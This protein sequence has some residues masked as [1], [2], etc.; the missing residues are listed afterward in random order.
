LSETENTGG[1]DFRPVREQ[2]A[3]KTGKA[4]RCPSLYVLQANLMGAGLKAWSQALINSGALSSSG[5]ALFLTRMLLVN[6]FQV[7]PG[8]GLYVLTFCMVLIPFLS[9]T[10]SI[11][12]I[13]SVI[14]R[15]RRIKMCLPIRIRPVAGQRPE[16]ICNSVDISRS[17]VL[18][19]TASSYYYVG[20]ET[21]VTRTA[22]GAEEHAS[23]VRVEKRKDGKYRVA[24]RI[25]TVA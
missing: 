8:P 24:L 11:P 2:A 22:T 19:E 12:R 1:Y 10:H 23:V 3:G 20:M 13:R 25:L 6:S 15:D 9:Y 18:V 4:L 21:Y 14:R 5:S 7:S 16:E 17:G